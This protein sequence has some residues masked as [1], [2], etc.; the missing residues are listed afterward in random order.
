[1]HDVVS[2][3][4]AYLDVFLG[5]ASVEYGLPMEDSIPRSKMD[6]TVNSLKQLDGY[7]QVLHDNREAISEQQITNIALAAGA[8]LGEVI[9]RNAHRKYQWLN[10]QAYFQTQPEKQGLF[11]YC[12]GTSAL[13]AASNTAMTLPINKVLRFIDE[14]PENSTDYYGGLE[15]SR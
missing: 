11:P 7:L 13:L 8:Y 6:F 12:T 9:R 2:L 10:Y 4:P 5:H 1:M 14:G 3:I 15:V